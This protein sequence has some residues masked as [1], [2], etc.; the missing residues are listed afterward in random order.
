MQ[1]CCIILL[2]LA[3][4]CNRGVSKGFSRGLYNYIAEYEL[5]CCVISLRSARL[6]PITRQRQH[7]IVNDLICLSFTALMDKDTIIIILYELDFIYTIMKAHCV[8]T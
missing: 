4:C 6:C 1:K 2:I 8:V 5:S 7:L 3:K